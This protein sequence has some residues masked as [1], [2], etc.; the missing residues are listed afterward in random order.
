MPSGP[1]C[2]LAL[3]LSKSVSGLIL[4]PVS[5]ATVF[6]LLPR[7]KSASRVFC[8]A[9]RAVRHQLVGG[10]VDG[11]IGRSGAA[12]ERRSLRQHDIERRQHRGQFLHFHARRGQLHV[13]NG[14]VVVLDAVSSGQFRLGL[15]DLHF[16][17]GERAG[18]LAQVIV[19]AKSK[20]TVF[21]AGLP[22]F[23]SLS[24]AA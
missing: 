2:T 3:M 4:M 11:H 7:S 5:L 18:A 1:E 8:I 6:I 17:A 10:A 20:P 16:A 22:L 19:K 23:A 21:V 13:Q 14:R 24:C 15:S 9:T 12:F